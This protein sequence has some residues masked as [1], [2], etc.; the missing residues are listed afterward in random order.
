MRNSSNESRK[1]PPPTGFVAVPKTP[2]TDILKSYEG[3]PP[4]IGSPNSVFKPVIKATTI[5]P[6]IPIPEKISLP[7]IPPKD[8]PLPPLLVKVPAATGQAK[9]SSLPTKAKPKLGSKLLPGV[10]KTSKSANPVNQVSHGTVKLI[11]RDKKPPSSGKKIKPTKPKAPPQVNGPGIPP[12]NSKQSQMISQIK[13]VSVAV[14]KVPGNPSVVKMKKL[15]KNV[16]DGISSTNSK[17]TK[18]LSNTTLPLKPKN[19]DQQLKK[20]K[21]VTKTKRKKQIGRAHV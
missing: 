14:S 13:P 21:F 20:T 10:T 12:D 18:R 5:F 15:K 2:A 11:P 7:P 8:I 19:K 1:S 17:A 16:L 9:E 3:P 4:E 6:L